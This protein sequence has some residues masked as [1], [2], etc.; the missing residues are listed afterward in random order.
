MDQPLLD[1]IDAALTEIRAMSATFPPA[2]SIERQL[3]WCRNYLLGVK[4]PEAPG[5]FSMG[6]I[7]TRE[8]DMYGDNPEL[9]SAINYIQRQI[10]AKL[11]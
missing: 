5:P 7:A 10:E 4:Q 9:A 8:F 11:R 6:L 3:E 2:E 1:K